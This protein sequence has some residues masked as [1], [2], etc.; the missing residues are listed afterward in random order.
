M[1]DESQL[2]HVPGY[3]SALGLAISGFFAKGYVGRVQQL[4]QAIGDMQTKV[5]AQAGRN[6]LREDLRALADRMDNGFSEIRQALTS[7]GKR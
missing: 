2:P 4:E 5:E 7:R 3:L 6:E 1:N